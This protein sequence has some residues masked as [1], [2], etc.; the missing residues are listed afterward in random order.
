MFKKLNGFY[1]RF[2]EKIL[3]GGEQPLQG[4]HNFKGERSFILSLSFHYFFFNTNNRI[5]EKNIGVGPGQTK[6]QFYSR[7]SQI[8]IFL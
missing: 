4:S 5:L 3:K 6:D 7:F 8:K 2:D 1:K